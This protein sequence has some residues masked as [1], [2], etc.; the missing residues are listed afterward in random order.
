MVQLIEKATFYA[1]P[2]VVGKPPDQPINQNPPIQPEIMT[3]SKNHPNLIFGMVLMGSTG[4]LIGL[5]LKS[6]IIISIMGFLGLIIGWL[7]GWVGGRRYLFIICLG[8][9]LGT[10]LGYPTGDR[11]VIVMAAGSGAAIAG[12]CGAQMEQ[13]IGK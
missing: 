11:D 8:L 5:I 9:V 1:P 7:I 12:F 4:V 3:K 6:Y 10:G 2:F 13:F